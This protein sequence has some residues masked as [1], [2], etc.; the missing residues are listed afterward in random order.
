MHHLLKVPSSQHGIWHIENAQWLLAIL[1]IVSYQDFDIELSVTFISSFCP[2]QAAV[3]LIIS[4][5]FSTVYSMMYWLK[6]QTG[7]T[8]QTANLRMKFNDPL[9][10]YPCKT[11]LCRSI[12]TLQS[13]VFVFMPNF[14][15]QKT[16]SHKK[17]CILDLIF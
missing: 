8:V 2:V 10:G 6:W 7:I 11:D 17:L 15:Q 13:S 5:S 12:L 14:C 1:S 16:G 9:Q 4:N 3:L